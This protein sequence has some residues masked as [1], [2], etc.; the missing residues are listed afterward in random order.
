MKEVF[1]KHLMQERNTQAD[2]ASTEYSL[3]RITREIPE[4]ED[5][6]ESKIIAMIGGLP[7]QN[8]SDDEYVIP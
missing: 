7:T 2:L 8:N 5:S 6:D 1:C 4:V 3:A